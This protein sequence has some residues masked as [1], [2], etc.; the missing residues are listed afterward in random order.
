MTTAGVW[1]VIFALLLR[2]GCDSS[3]VGG[4]R[5]EVLSLPLSYHDPTMRTALD[6]CR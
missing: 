4:V 3:S 2:T 1:E 6:V 5:E